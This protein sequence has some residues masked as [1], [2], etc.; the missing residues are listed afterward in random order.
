MASASAGSGDYFILHSYFVSKRRTSL[1][2][3]ARLHVKEQAK[4]RWSI[5]ASKKMSHDENEQQ[6]ISEKRQSSLSFKP[7]RHKEVH[8]LVARC[9][10]RPHRL[11]SLGH[12]ETGNPRHRLAHQH[13]HRSRSSLLA[14][15][16]IATKL[17]MQ[18]S[19][20]YFPGGFIISVILHVQIF[21]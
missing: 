5:G 15:D 11:A 19:W 10:R 3:S 9:G 20:E 8:P 4:R 2:L 17:D 18:S 13:L 14:A 12:P 1:P 6:H 16:Y 7:Q 21:H